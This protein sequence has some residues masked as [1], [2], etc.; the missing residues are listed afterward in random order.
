MLFQFFLLCLRDLLFVL[1]RLTLVF[2]ALLFE[3]L[4]LE[5]AAWLHLNHCLLHRLLFFLNFLLWLFLILSGG[6]VII[7]YA[8]VFLRSHTGAGHSDI[9]KQGGFEVVRD[10]V[11]LL[12]IGD[13]YLGGV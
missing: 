12:L 2:N 3:H 7:R 5:N 1:G 10:L 4:E 13:L 8:A 9:S 11:A 6:M